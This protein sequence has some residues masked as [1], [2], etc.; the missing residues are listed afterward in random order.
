MNR[1]LRLA[2]VLVAAAAVSAA[3]AGSTRTSKLDG[4]WEG[5][6]TRQ[7]LIQAGASQALAAKLHGSWTAKFGTGRFAFHDRDTGADSRGRF[8]VG[9]EKVRF[10]FA[11]GVGIKKGQVAELTW[12]LYR[13]RLRFRAIP[14]R[15]SMFLDLFVWTRSS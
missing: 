6:L 8:V 10:V 11:S 3:A 1:V 15:A 2:I 14:G 5:S 13:D 7:Q 9:G 4:R 12:S